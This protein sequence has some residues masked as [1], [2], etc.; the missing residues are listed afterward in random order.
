MLEN[1]IQNSVWGFCSNS[2]RTPISFML[3]WLQKCNLRLPKYLASFKK[4]WFNKLTWQQCHCFL[5]VLYLLGTKL[6]SVTLMAVIWQHFISSFFNTLFH[7]SIQ[8]N[9]VAACYADFI[10]IVLVKLTLNVWKLKGFFLIFFF[11]E[12]VIPF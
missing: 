8:I 1:Y 9:L 11:T 10:Y 3:I 12:Y 6:L 4:K 5:H 2:L 7:F